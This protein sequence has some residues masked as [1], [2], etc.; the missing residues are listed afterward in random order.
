M[1]PEMKPYTAP[2][3]TEYG[4]VADLTAILGN[5]FTGDVLVDTTGNVEQSGNLSLDACP[6]RNPHAGGVCEINP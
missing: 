6:T 2:K 3:I 1:P 4:D 5:A